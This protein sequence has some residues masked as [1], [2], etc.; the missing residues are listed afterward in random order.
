MPKSDPHREIPFDERTKSGLAHEK[1]HILRGI[2]V[3]QTPDY[4]ESGRNANCHVSGKGK[5]RKIEETREKRAKFALTEEVEHVRE[6]AP[7]PRHLN[8]AN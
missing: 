8:V 2:Y 6:P 5:S 1:A 3:L 4:T 7:Q